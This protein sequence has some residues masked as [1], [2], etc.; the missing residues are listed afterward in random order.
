MKTTYLLTLLPKP[1]SFPAVDTSRA[2]DSK[3]TEI[4]AP[5]PLESSPR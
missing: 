1:S 4:M 3:V 5:V 2:E